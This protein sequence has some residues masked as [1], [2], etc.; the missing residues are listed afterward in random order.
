[1]G[2]AVQ[3]LRLCRPGQP[4]R[5]AGD[6]PGHRH[7]IAAD[8][9][10]APAACVVSEA[11]V[12][13]RLL[14]IAQVVAK[15]SLDHPDLSDGAVSDQLDQ[16]VSL[17]VAAVHK[18]F[19]QE[20]VRLSHRSQ[21]QLGLGGIHRERLFAEHVF[22]RTRRLDRPFQMQVVGQ[23]VIDDIHRVVGE[24]L[25]IA[26][27]SARHIELP[28][29]CLGRLLSA[30]AYSNEFPGLGRTKAL[31]ELPGDAAGADDAPSDFAHAVHF[32][33]SFPGMPGYAASTKAR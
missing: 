1:M 16:L 13:V 7:R 27:V 9:H 21:R 20:H 6:Q 15:C 12:A 5:C 33:H 26:A 30:A 31:G 2:N 19:H 22:A 10:D 23:R 8:I 11:D 29:E 17:R 24:Q 28:A 18:G 4:H 32:L 25:R 14:S 3:A